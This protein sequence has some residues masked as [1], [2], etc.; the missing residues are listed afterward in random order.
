MRAKSNIGI[1]NPIPQIPPPDP[2]PMLTSLQ[3]DSSGSWDAEIRIL[4]SNFTTSSVVLANNQV[5]QN[6]T[7]ISASELRVVVPGIHQAGVYPV[8]VRNGSQESNALSFT[9][10]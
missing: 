3:P 9:A 1:G 10:F 4:G 7:Y 6:V 8:K 5:V 2:I